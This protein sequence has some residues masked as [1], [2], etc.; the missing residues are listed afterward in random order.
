MK[1]ANKGSPEEAE[2]KFKVIHRFMLDT[3]T[4]EYSAKMLARSLTN[5]STLQKNCETFVEAAARVLKSRRLADQVGN[6]LAGTYLCYSKN[7]ITLDEA[8][9]CIEKHDWSDHTAVASKSDEERLIDKIATH[10]IRVTTKHGSEDSTLG[11]LIIVASSGE[12]DGN[13]TEEIAEKELK[14]FGIKTTRTR[15]YIANRSEPMKKLLTDSPWAGDWGRPLKD[16]NGGECAGVMY[17][18]PGIKSRATR[19]PIELFQA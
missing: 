7:E 1:S 6:M 15:V 12:Y 11:E 4:P 8:V 9:K 13:V 5:L 19:L 10:R 16:L 2:K 18:T 3:F 17:F 14:R